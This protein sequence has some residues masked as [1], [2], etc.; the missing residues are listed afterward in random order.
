MPAG[1]GN[2]GAEFEVLRVD[3][4]GATVRRGA[5]LR[6]CR[7]LINIPNDVLT[8]NGQF[9]TAPSPTPSGTPNPTV[10]STPSATASPWP[11]DTPAPTVTRVPATATATPTRVPQPVYL[12]LTLREECVS[13]QKRID[14]ALVIDAS[15]SMLEPTTAWQTKLDAARAA[16]RTFLD[17]LRLDV[18]DQAAIIAF[19]SNAVVLQTLT[20]DRRLL[21]QALDNI[22]TGQQTRIHF[23]IEAATT[24]L[25]GPQHR[26]GNA[27]AMVVLTDGRA[28]PDSPDLAVQTGRA[29]AAH[30]IAVFTI[31]LGNEVDIDALE[32]MAS[33]AAYFYRAPKA[34]D[35]EGIYK[36]IAVAIPCPAGRFWGK[37]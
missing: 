9:R 15:T 24:E 1:A 14:V 20:A 27:A 34:E 33:Q 28:N 3:D 5:R 19:N 4:G 16:V 21:D 11:T 17:Q 22:Q 8:A 36:A 37:R 18:G 13:A 30:G 25:T 23:G 7:E 35:L 12:P 10:T 32:R 2:D 31:G 26:T 6:A 29:A